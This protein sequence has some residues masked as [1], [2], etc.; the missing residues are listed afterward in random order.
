MGSAARV[1][2]AVAGPLARLATRAGRA[3]GRLVARAGKIGGLAVLGGL[4]IFVLDLILVRDEGRPPEVAP[5]E[6]K[7][8]R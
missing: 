4:L 6:P 5:R 1:A 3:V 8:R 2:L 7:L